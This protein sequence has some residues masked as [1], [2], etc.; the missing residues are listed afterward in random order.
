MN[1][2]VAIV[3][4][5]AITVP[6][7]LLISGHSP[8]TSDAPTDEV[9]VSPTMADVLDATWFDSV[10][11][12]VERRIPMLDVAVAVDSRVSRTVF[13][14][15]PNPEVTIGAEGWLFDNESLDRACLSGQYFAAI[16]DEM[17]RADAVAAAAGIEFLYWVAPDKAAVVSDELSGGRSACTKANVAALDEHLTSAAVSLLPAFAD[18]ADP[19]TLFYRTD[20]HW[21]DSGGLVAS[22]QIIERLA[23]G[24]WDEHA[25]VY[26]S[27][28]YDTDLSRLISD[29]KTEVVTAASVVFDG[30]PLIS[31]DGSSADPMGDM[32]RSV[33][34]FEFPDGPA[35]EGQTVVAYDSFGLPQVDDL[36]PYFA[37]S[38]FV[39]T[40]HFD[41]DEAAA[42]VGSADRL[43]WGR[44]Q[45][46]FIGGD[47]ELPVSSWLVE[48]FVDRLDPVR[49][50]SAELTRIE[51]DPS[52]EIYLV[53]RDLRS[54]G[55]HVFPPSGTIFD[56]K[57][58]VHA[59]RVRGDLEFGFDP[60][61][62]EVERVDI[63]VQE[64]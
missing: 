56:D 47:L 13:A 63:P 5:L 6:G 32:S 60:D 35:I 23:P 7:V 46:K 19:D 29:A 12:M 20:T 18:H 42:V 58:R 54:D 41:E 3:F 8:P 11:A 30:I 64:S 36:A 14:D 34:S 2:L 39:Y 50:D 43:L 49:I 10:D 53:V 51:M 17:R 25:V 45:R 38:T 24:L 4:L 52:I 16:G 26:G 21:N 31:V 28:S 48:A 59:L 37:S 27:R 15:S 33:R 62:F 61:H 57:S 55:D 22:R 44:V 1:R 40:P 9:V